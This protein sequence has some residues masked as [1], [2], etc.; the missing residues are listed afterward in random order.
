VADPTGTAVNSTSTS[1]KDEFTIKYQSSTTVNFGGDGILNAGDV[2]T[3]K[4]GL[5]VGNVASNLVTSLNPGQ[6]G[7]NGFFDNGFNNN[8]FLSFKFDN[9][10]GTVDSVVS[11]FPALHYDSGVIH[12][13]IS[14]NGSTF[15]NFMDL[16][17]L[18]SFLQGG[19]NLEVVGAVSFS[20]I[21]NAFVNT[22]HDATGT[23]FYDTW[24][25]NG[26]NFLTMNF[27]IDQNTN[28]QAATVTPIANGEIISSNHDGSVA[29]GSV[30]E[31]GSLAL[32]GIGLLGFRR[33]QDRRSE[34]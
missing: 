24:L 30:P 2:V 7:V 26:T 12:M 29:F 17:V 6:V 21:S 10:G 9:L 13:L 28:P 19:V 11:G 31:P 16:V 8:W 32:I 25:A 1:L 22:F 5:D 18:N 3:T 4:G 23:S 15:T 33:L 27:A 20:G 34:A 14:N